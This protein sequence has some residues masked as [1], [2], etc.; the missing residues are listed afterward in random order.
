MRHLR[1]TQRRRRLKT[2]LSTQE[3]IVARDVAILL[4]KQY[5]ALKRDLRR[6]NFRKRAIHAQINGDLSKA[7]G[8]DWHAWMENFTASLKDTLGQAVD[9]LHQVERWFW[10]D[11]DVDLGTLD[12]AVVIRAYEA[13]AGRQITDIADD[14]RN[15]VLHEI[16]DWYNDPEQTLPDLIEKLGQYFSPER[17]ESIARTET[18]HIASQVARDTMEQL[19]LDHFNVDLAAEE[20]GFPCT[21]CIAQAAANPHLL[22]DDMP[23]Y[24]VLCRCNVAYVGIGE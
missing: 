2:V 8:L 10:R 17:A 11:Y 4:D 24:H 23:P 14:T 6:A 13:R 9:V 20:G 3:Q 12:P 21:F 15:K 19:N 18:S 5:K 22:S 7:V 16:T 1:Q